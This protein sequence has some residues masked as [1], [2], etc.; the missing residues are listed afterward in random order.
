[1]LLDLNG[2]LGTNYFGGNVTVLSTAI[3][4]NVSDVTHWGIG[5]NL[6]NNG[7]IVGK[8]YG[9]ISFEGN[10]IITGTKS[11]KI[12]TINVDGTYTIGTT[13][14]LTTNTPTLNG[15]L[16]F[17]LAR[18]NRVILASNI[19]T[20]Y[21]S[22]AL[23]V[24]NSGPAPGAGNSYQ[25]FQAASYGGAFSSESFPPLGSGLSWVDDLANSGSISVSSGAT[26]PLI[27][28]APASVSYGQTFFV[29]TSGAGT[30]PSRARQYQ[31]PAMGWPANG[32]SLEGVKM[33]KR[34][35]ASSCSEGSTNTVSER[36]ISRAI[37][38]ICSPVSP[39]PSGKTASGLPEKAC[40]VN[41]SSWVKL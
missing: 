12:P 13:I 32:S 40:S 24:I 26:Q 30:I 11:I 33:R 27:T 19:G 6:T 25:L 20:L 21:Y 14:T 18:T 36:F 16:V 17:D 41:T 9:S 38:C 10:G 28:S 35:S 34:R 22:G 1:L 29:G 5:G 37:C 39:S 7:T 15:T 2:A 3:G 31:V 23:N 4:W 8:G